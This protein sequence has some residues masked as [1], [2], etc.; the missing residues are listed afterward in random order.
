[1]ASLADQ[2]TLC[3]IGRCCQS[4]KAVF[5]CVHLSLPWSVSIHVFFHLSAWD[6]LLLKSGANGSSPKSLWVF[7]ILHVFPQ[8]AGYYRYICAC[9]CVKGGLSYTL[10]CTTQACAH[11][12]VCVC[13]CACSSLLLE[14]IWY[15]QLLMCMHAFSG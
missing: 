15:R 14:Q 10:L 11:V 2:C 9:L 3:S 4:R 5:D 1:M 13:V 7:Y 6:K 8:W 12:S